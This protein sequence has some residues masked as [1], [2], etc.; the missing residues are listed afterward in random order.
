MYCQHPEN[1][2]GMA[3]SPISPPSTRKLRRSRSKKVSKLFK[4]IVRVRSTSVSSNCVQ[5]LVKR[6]QLNKIIC[7]HQESETISCKKKI[8]VDV[9]NDMYNPQLTLILRPYGLEED[10]RRYVTLEVLID[11]PKRAPK[12]KASTNVKLV[13][14]IS[15][16]QSEDKTITITENLDLRVFYRKKFLSHKL[17]RESRS[18]T[19]EITAQAECIKPST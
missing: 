4:R 19:V 10:V 13:L 17:L 3:A 15:K 1:E 11:V 18:D 6:D 12:L 16:I 7:R 8:E 5:W 14:T 2:V 9:G